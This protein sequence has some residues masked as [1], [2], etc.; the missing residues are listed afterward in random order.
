MST[1]G[2]ERL[3]FS[4]PGTL[5]QKIEEKE[6]SGRRG[7]KRREVTGKMVGTTEKRWEV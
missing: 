7:W 4:V 3:V 2:Q 1:S 6:G 5:K